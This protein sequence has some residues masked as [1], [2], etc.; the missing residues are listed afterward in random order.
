MSSDQKKSSNS[1]NGGCIGCLFLLIFILVIFIALVSGESGGGTG[2]GSSSSRS[3][4]CHIC[5]RT[6]TDSENVRSIRNT[7]MCKRCYSNYRT[8]QDYKDSVGNMVPPISAAICRAQG[9]M[10]QHSHTVSI[11]LIQ[12]YKPS[13]S[14][15]LDM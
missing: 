13:R 6:F 9:A 12:Q 15:A 7:N 8:L 1:N 10:R 5:G 11:F 4:E 2:S 3:A 14:L